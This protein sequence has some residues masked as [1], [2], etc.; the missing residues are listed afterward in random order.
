MKEMYE[1]LLKKW[2]DALVE[3]AC[4]RFE[5]VLLKK[6]IRAMRNKLTNK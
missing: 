5:M 4:L 6:E 2:G 3:I 1:D